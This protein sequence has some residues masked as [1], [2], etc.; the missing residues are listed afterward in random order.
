MIQIQ[1]CQVCFSLMKVFKL[2]MLLDFKLLKSK[3][4]SK[5][6]SKKKVDKKVRKIKA[7]KK[8][9]KDT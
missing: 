5:K 1:T 8:E 2:R 3:K 6:E 4:D 7:R 9:E